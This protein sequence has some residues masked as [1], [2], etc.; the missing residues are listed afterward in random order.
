MDTFL[1][2]ELF[3][4]KLVSPVLLGSGTLIEKFEDISP[5]VDAG[6]GG[7]VPRTTRKILR[8]Q[9]HPV[10]HLYQTD[11]RKF[12]NLINAEWTGA[13][14]DYW[15]PY[16]DGMSG[17]EKVVMSVS[18]RDIDECIEVCRELDRYGGWLYFEINVSCAHSN[19]VHGYIN[20]DKAHVEE[21]C[22]KLKS[23]AL[24]TPIAIKFGHSEYLL[25]LAKIVEKCGIKGIVLLNTY[26]PVFD[27]S[28][29]KGRPEAIV[30]IEGSMGGLSGSAIFNIALTDVAMIRSETNLEIV[31]CGGVYGYEQAVKFLMAGASA[32]QVYTA[33]HL[34]GVNGP[35]VIRKI[36]SELSEYLKL[37]RYGSVGE[38]G[39][40]A[41]KLLENRTNM[42]VVVPTVDTATCI[43]CNL[44][45][46]ICLPGAIAPIKVNDS[47]NSVV[48]IDDEKCVG[49]G[50]C[51]HVCPTK[52][53]SLSMYIS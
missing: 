1:S 28:I 18:G 21:L 30:G 29:E 41:L 31:G 10:P 37:H 22:T 19:N 2:T 6:I 50:H 51:V 23:S 12:A 53:N 11:R 32:V 25:E 44:C 26:G 24:N 47:A 35:S 45:V 5:Y 13:S 38:L 42:K 46:P 15:R 49:C 16:L 7:V 36:N 4:K 33:A 52:P 20:K 48:A 8:R 40:L 34:K 27:F 3:G 43:G 9:T 17:S 39:G 14:I